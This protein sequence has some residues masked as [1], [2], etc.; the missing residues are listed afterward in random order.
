M[1][2][3]Y[4]C[5]KIHFS[6]INHYFT[7]WNTMANKEGVSY[8]DSQIIVA[9]QDLMLYAQWLPTSNTHN[10]HTY[11][12][13]GLSVL[14]AVCNI[15]AESPEDFGDYFAWGEISPKRG[16]STY[17]LETYKFGTKREQLTKYCTSSS[18]GRNSL[19]DNKVTL[20]LSDNTAHVNWGGVGECQQQLNLLN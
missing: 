14:W 8:C 1:E 9:T 3:L 13:L 18:Y 12:D 16:Y 4:N 20:E 17:N 15:G 11:I 10:G 5:L 2:I 19:I 7:S 6:F